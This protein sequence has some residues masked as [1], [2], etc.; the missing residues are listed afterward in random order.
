[1]SGILNDW[2]LPTC[3][4]ITRTGLI[5]D[6]RKT[7]QR[8][9]LQQFALR[10]KA[11]FTP[12]RD[13]VGCTIV[14]RWQRRLKRYFSEDQTLFLETRTRHGSRFLQASFAGR[15]ISSQSQTEGLFASGKKSFLRRLN[16]LA[17]DSCYVTPTDDGWGLCLRHRDDGSSS[18]FSWSTLQK[19]TDS[20]DR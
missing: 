7:R 9:G 5:L 4:I 14:M 19:T 20:D 11:R 2:C 6:S 10:L 8:V 17:N 15:R 18:T 13:S 12:F 16:D 1:M 3:F